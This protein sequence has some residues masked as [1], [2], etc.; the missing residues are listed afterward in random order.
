MRRI[1]DSS[2]PIAQILRQNPNKHCPQEILDELVVL[3]VEYISFDSK[4]H[5][6]Q[7]AVHGELAEDV[8]GAF[9]L[10]MDEKFPVQT[11]IP[12]SSEKFL[13][14]DDLSMVHNNTSSF[15][16]RFV[17]DTTDMSNHS[18]G[19]AVDINPRLNPCFLKKGVFP[20]HSCYDTTVSGTILQDSK[21]VQYFKKLGWEWGGDWNTDPDYHHFEKVAE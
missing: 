3:D 9:N 11:V 8:V 15:N 10:L 18:T 4:L 5:K 14:D 21:L 17:R 1:V 20:R 12:I 2:L 13:W 7:I 6:G 19:R 16:F